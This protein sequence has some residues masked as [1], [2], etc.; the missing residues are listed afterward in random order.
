[1]LFLEIVTVLLFL[2]SFTGLCFLA[3]RHRTWHFAALSIFPL[4]LG[5]WSVLK[6]ADDVLLL[7]V[8]VGSLLVFLIV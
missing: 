1:M 5:G 8:G 2:A 7:V 3:L 4:F 6:P